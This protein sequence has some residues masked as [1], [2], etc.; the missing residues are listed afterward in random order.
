MPHPLHYYNANHSKHPLTNH[1]RLLLLSRPVQSTIANGSEILILEY[2][3]DHFWI[4]LPDEMTVGFFPT[5]QQAI[6]F[7][8]SLPAVEILEADSPGSALD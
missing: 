4:C 1:L 2:L 5:E 3:K 8:H 6:S 7:A